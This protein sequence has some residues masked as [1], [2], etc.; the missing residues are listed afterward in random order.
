MPQISLKNLWL[1]LVGAL[2][3]LPAFAQDAMTSE[4]ADSL[5]GE[6]ENR[7]AYFSECLQGV[8]IEADTLASQQGEE[9]EIDWL[10]E[11]RF[12]C[13]R[14]SPVTRR[15]AVK[16]LEWGDTI[17][18][19]KGAK[20]DIDKKE[21]FEQGLE[22][23]RTALSEDTLDHLNYETMSMSFAA[24]ISVSGLRGKAHMA[25]SVRIY[26]EECIALE[27]KNDRA[28]HIL[29]RW[30]YE[31]SKLG[32]FTRMLAKVFFGESP[33]GSFQRAI[34]YFNKAIEL[35]NIVVHRYWLGMT[36]LEEGEKDK[37][38]EQFRILQS[39]PLVQ[40]NDEYFKKEARKILEKYS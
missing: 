39:L 26:A 30:H 38:L 13:E 19:D 6:E 35:D 28:Y 37:A 32:W 36:Y 15:V 16:Y 23:S 4:P 12:T 17:Y 14:S 29:G 31:V 33:E 9:A 1:L 2:F 34:G 8:F 21:L 18:D 10:K 22:W 11:N 7:Y 25:D 24:I 27:P 5:S 40:H 20:E 3:A